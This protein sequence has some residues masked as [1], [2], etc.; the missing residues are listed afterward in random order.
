MAVTYVTSATDINGG[1]D[2]VRPT[3]YA[4]NYP[5]SGTWGAGDCI[6]FIGFWYDS[7]GATMTAPSGF[8]Q[9]GGNAKRIANHTNIVVVEACWR[10]ATTGEG[11]SYNASGTA[12]SQYNNSMVI[13][14]RGTDQTAPLD[15]ASGNSGQGT[16]AT[17]TGVTPARNGSMAVAVH[18]GYNSPTAAIGST[19]TM[20]ERIN[21]LDGVNDLSTADY[22]TTDTASRTATLTSDTWGALFLIFQPPA[23]GGATSDPAFSASRRNIRTNA[24]YRMSEP[25]GFKRRSRIYVPASLAP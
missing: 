20:T 24:I 25:S 18:A 6:V 10:I 3:G 5:I 15:V 7:T 16:T 12:D 19:P 22:G 21:A 13:V 14:L 1:L 23:A 17:W 9:P 11:A 8:T 4:T 2:V